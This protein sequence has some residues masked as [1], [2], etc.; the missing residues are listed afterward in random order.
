M[1]KLRLTT[2]E[3]YRT[4][5]DMTI[6]NGYPPTVAEL[7]HE[8]GRAKTAA[9]NHLRNMKRRGITINRW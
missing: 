1:A 3:V 7:A 4:L 2:D 6:K 8:I 5:I 9:D